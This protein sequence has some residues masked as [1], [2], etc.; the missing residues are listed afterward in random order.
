MENKM[1]S[2]ARWYAEHGFPVLPLKEGGKQ[3]ICKGGY[4]SATT[5]A[6]QVIE[7]WM[8]SPNANIGIATGRQSDGRSLV[9][10]D[11]DTHNGQDGYGELQRY[12]KRYPALPPTLTAKTGG[13]GVHLLYLSDKP[14]CCKT[15]ILGDFCGYSGGVDVK[16]AG[17]YIVVPPSVTQAPYE[18]QGVCS[19][20][21]IADGGEA[22]DT[23]MRVGKVGIEGERVQA[24]AV[25]PP[26]LGDYDYACKII[27][28]KG[29]TFNE[30]C[31][32][33]ELHKLAC[34]LQA[35]GF[36]D[37]DIYE[38][39]GRVNMERC[40]PPLPGREVETLVA[41]AVRAIA[42]G[43]RQAP[44]RSDAKAA[45][46][47]RSRESTP[48][49]K[50]D[51][52]RGKL[53][54][55]RYDNFKEYLEGLTP[56]TLLRYNE[57][58]R[59]IDISGRDG[60]YQELLHETLPATLADELSDRFCG[61]TLQKV[62]D[63]M[64]KV[65]ADNNY[66]PVRELIENT[67]WDG[68]DR[69]E[70]IFKLFNIENDE[71]SRAVLKKWLMQAVCVLYN[72][73]ARPFSADIVIVFQGRQGLGKTRFFEK[74]ALGF[75]GEGKTLDTRNKDSI[76]EITRK[77]IS[78]LGEIG[79][80][81]RKDIDSMKAFLS[82]STDEYR[83]PYGRTGITYARRTVFVGTVNEEDYLADQ[84]GNRRF[85]TIPLSGDIDIDYERDVKP[86][87]AEQLWAQV[88]AL[89][90]TEIAQ[91]SSSYGAVFRLSAEELKAM[92]RRN[93]GY[94]KLMRGEQEV[95]DALASYDDLPPHI[96]AVPRFQTATD[97]KIRNEDYL[98]A[99]DA[100]SIGKVLK[101]LG[102]EKRVDGHSRKTVY[103]LPIKVSIENA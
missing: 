82:C 22:L 25:S 88:A 34:C 31:R 46:V 36:A 101:K 28:D 24:P 9:V 1:L 98:R 80:T 7:W 10:V 102:V 12:M 27:S 87:N 67:P 38:L 4:K 13:G 40:S 30:G 75:F 62:C 72:D 39:C 65:A 60:E 94:K 37:S 85:A 73:V 11:C 18:W 14:Y 76:M 83:A 56:P 32:N 90:K 55:L 93:G 26:L 43:T 5:D 23:L 17:G 51:N 54:Q 78:E 79:S 47:P 103:K 49:S 66:N 3:P 69:I 96:K 77:W 92:E 89:V 100:A 97:F 64:T 6:A 68:V 16:G 45:G 99:V 19:M 35:R 81:M 59:K 52:K 33:D 20:N 86:F 41:S 50:P 71:L 44:R 70:Q 74:L 91:R 42:K 57:I 29:Y 58:T 95:M 84:T 48:E 15:N 61:V 2:A 63:Y 21:N 8:Q 53:P